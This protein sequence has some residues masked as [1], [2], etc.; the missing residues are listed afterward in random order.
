MM[1]LTRA[2]LMTQRFLCPLGSYEAPT[3]EVAMNPHADGS[4]KDVDTFVAR[5]SKEAFCDRNDIVGVDL[6]CLVDREPLLFRLS[7]P[8]NDND[9][10]VGAV[11]VTASQ[12]NGIKDGHAV[13]VRIRARPG[14]LSED[15]KWT[16]RGDLDIDT[17]LLQISVFE[18]VCDFYFQSPRG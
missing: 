15:I 6:D 5:R 12:S 14:Y 7:I 3:V 10:F 8:A 18:L 17:R 13:D 16:I 2:A 1:T 9:F 4:P 11:R